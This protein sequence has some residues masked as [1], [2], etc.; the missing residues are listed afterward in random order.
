MMPRSPKAI[1]NKKMKFHAD[2]V[3][4]DA[5][6]LLSPI[7]LGWAGAVRLSSSG[8]LFFVVKKTA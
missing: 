8:N 4:A 3:E 1:L 5:M 2:V 7:G 6:Y